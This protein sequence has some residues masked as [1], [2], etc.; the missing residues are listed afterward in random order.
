MSK[1]FSLNLTKKYGLKTVLN[2]VS[3][4]IQKKE[5]VWLLGPNGAWKDIF[6]LYSSWSS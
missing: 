2:N 6:F 1:L 5:I 4:E 3:I